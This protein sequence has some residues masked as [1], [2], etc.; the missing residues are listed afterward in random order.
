MAVKLQEMQ[1][2]CAGDLAIEASCHS[3]AQLEMPAR[4]LI[5]TA[6]KQLPGH[7]KTLMVP[8]KQKNKNKNSAN[9]CNHFPQ[10]IKIKYFF[11]QLRGQEVGVDGDRTWHSSKSLPKRPSVKTFLD[12]VVRC[13][14][15]WPETAISAGLAQPVP[16][17]FHAEN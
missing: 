14:R 6:V 4:P 2:G 8:E 16:V 15:K 9:G 12:S 11:P 10:L 13:C 17:A 1:T 5:Q 7:E 3:L